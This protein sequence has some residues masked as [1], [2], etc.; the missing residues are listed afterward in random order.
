MNELREFAR[1]SKDL[2]NLGVRLIPISADD[3]EHARE[4]WGKAAERKFTILSDPGSTVIRKYGLV[5]EAGHRGSDI[6][7]RTTILINP[8][9]R[10]QWRR[11][12]QTVPDI[13]TWD[14]TLSMIRK[15]QERRSTDQNH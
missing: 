14:E 4:A 8:E 13:P 11:V 10:E 3:Q 7:L 5:H 9:G 6:A 15:A 1:H 12:S 2:E